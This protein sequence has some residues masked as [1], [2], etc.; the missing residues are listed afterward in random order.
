MKRAAS[1]SQLSLKETAYRYIRNQIANGK[2]V[3]GMRLSDLELAKAIGISRTPVREAIIQL[4]SQGFV[5]QKPGLGPQVH[6]VDRPELEE[7]LEFRE[8]IEGAAIAKA[9]E[10]ITDAELQDLASICGRQLAVVRAVRDRGEVSPDAVTADELDLLESAFH[11][12]L[13]KAARN[14]RLMQ[15]VK[16]L[17]VVT[18]V[19]ARRADYPPISWLRRM[20]VACHHHHRIAKALATRDQAKAQ[21]A[22]QCHLR[23]VTCYHLAAYDWQLREQRDGDRL[24]AVMPRDVR[25]L[26]HHMEAARK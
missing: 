17:S 16:D 22:V 13:M 25:R 14:R 7:I 4:Q 15:A 20:A 12:L 8:V 2:L 19:L 11:L 10:R 21:H 23:H 5:E 3:P 18:S 1:T 9:A 26:I 6:A 24:T